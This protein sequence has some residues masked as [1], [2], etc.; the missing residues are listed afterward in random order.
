MKIAQIAELAGVSMVPHSWST[1]IIK[2]A[3]LHVV[4]AMRT[5][6]FFEYC[7]QDTVLNQELVT[8]RFPVTDGMV[9]VPDGPGLGIEIDDD[10]VRRYSV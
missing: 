2:A 8:D 7:V 1:G 4:A 5:A 6:T 9:R 3:S 10:V